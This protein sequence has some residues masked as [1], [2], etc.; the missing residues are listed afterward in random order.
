MYDCVRSESGSEL[1]RQLSG[2]L[3]KDNKH[4][5]ILCL[6]MDMCMRSESESTSHSSPTQLKGVQVIPACVHYFANL[7][8]GVCWSPGAH[9][10][11]KHTHT[12]TQA[13]PKTQANACQVM[14]EN[15]HLHSSSISQYSATRNT[16]T[17]WSDESPV[18]TPGNRADN[19]LLI[20]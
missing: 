17:H 20:K 15:Q 5:R 3:R 19:W 9:R 13:T 10:D 14:I 4:T 16:H 6:C 2:I 12:H 8:T 18:K 1:G 11:T 7:S